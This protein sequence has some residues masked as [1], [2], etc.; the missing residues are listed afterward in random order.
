MGEVAAARV[1]GILSLE[2]AAKVICRRSRLLR[3][4]AGKGAMGLVELGMAE[5]QRALAGYEDR[6]SVAVSNGPQSTVISGDPAALEEVLAALEARSVFCRRVKVDVASH[7]PQMDPLRDDLFSTLRNVRPR[8]GQLAMRST[9][10][11]EAL[12]GPEC[13]ASY[14]VK[15]L[16]EPV[17]FSNAVQRLIETQ[18][19]LF[20]EMSP[21]PILLPAIEEN[22][23]DKKQVGT[24]VGS[25]RRNAD[26]RRTMLQGLGA[27]YA[28]GYPVDW[29]SLAP[30]DGRCVPLPAYPWQRKRYWIQASAATARTGEGTGHPLLG[31]CVPVAGMSAVYE[32]M[33]GL[34]THPWL[35]D[36]RV[37]G[38]ALVPGA[39]V[40]EL[41]RAAGAD[42]ATS[43]SG[44]TGLVLQA[45]L[46]LPETGARRVQVVLTD[47]ASA[48]VYSQSAESTARAAW[49]LHATASVTPEIAAPPVPVDLSALKA[50]CAE[51]L[52]V[53][54]IHAT[55]AEAGIAYGPA[56]RG[57]RSLWR[58]QG[59]SL[60]EVALPADVGAKG[61]GVHPALLDAAFHAVAAALPASSSAKGEMLLPFEIGSLAVHVAGAKVAWVHARARQGAG[62]G[63]V[64][65]DVTLADA[66]GTVLVEVTDLRLRPADREALRRVNGEP[67][68][69]AF[70]Q[71][72]WREAPLPAAARTQGDGIWVVVA[73]PASAA[74][75]ALEARLASC[76]VTEP[77]GL[78]AT[79]AGA[80][81]VAGV[82]CL[83]EASAGEAPP[84]TALRVA[85]LGLAVVRA[86][87][88]RA[89]VRLWWVTPG[90]VAVHGG[91]EVRA[92]TSPIWG[93]GRTVMQEHE[94][95]GC[96]LIDL[97][98]GEEGIDALVRELSASGGETQVAWRDGRRFVARLARA[99]RGDAEPPAPMRTDGT[100]LVTGGLGALGLHVARWLAG[101]G[102]A[103]LLLT[104]RRGRD[105]PGAADAVSALEALGARVTVAAVDV[106]DREALRAV[107]D[108]IP[109][110]WPLRAVVHTAGV[111]D[112]G[113][114]AE[115]SADRFA[116]VLSPKVD[117]AWN[118]HEL[119]AGHPLDRFVLFSS[120]SGLLGAAG[121]GNYAAANTFLDAL[122]AHRR[123]RGLPGQSLAWG[124]WSEAGLAAALD[125]AKRARLT[126]Q[127]FRWMSPAEGIALFERALSRPEA[128]LG[129]TPLDLAALS[130]SFGASVPPVWQALVRAPAASPAAA[131][132][133][134][135]AAQLAALPE[136][137]RAE[138]VRAAV[139]ADAGR[140]LG[141]GGASAAPLDRPFS[142]LG[143][144]SLTAVE[145]RN[146]LGK[147]LG[148]KLSTTLAFDHPTINALTR[149]LLA[150]V[151]LV[152]EPGAV[153][154]PS[155]GVP[156]AVADAT[157]DVD[158]HS[159]LRA[160]E[161]TRTLAGGR[162]ARFYRR[163][164]AGPTLLFLHGFGANHHYWATLAASLEQ[165]DLLIPSLPGRCGTDG[166]AL[167]TVSEAA[168]W[169]ASIS[170]PSWGSG[171]WWPSAT[172]M[173][174]PSPWSSPSSR[175]RFRPR[176]AT[177]SARW[178]SR[179]RACPWTRSSRRSCSPVRTSPSRPSARSP[180]SSAPAPG[181]PPRRASATWPEP[182]R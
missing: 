17:R 9:V 42:G 21:H 28:A 37:A 30:P 147:R 180:F 110:E 90:A 73:A 144:D 29:R 170:S 50:R 52:D 101:E 22:L 46:V 164:G 81:S 62:A 132:E 118:L 38:H 88:D 112:D 98:P 177:S 79:L 82:V 89:P 141:F 136:A 131:P 107:L 135:W 126:R 155:P 53:T 143:L 12:K 125:S 179:R 172:R 10:T 154:P 24:A 1:A 18:H 55:L 161:E 91:E 26:E 14:W 153:P 142:E 39:A 80:T 54:A 168:R 11:G 85:T 43:G 139:Q 71:L 178:R 78:A 137:R 120:V 61:Y 157:S 165:R 7:S 123:A 70:Y 56:F 65:A 49:T 169:I 3:R 25:L 4:V 74:A 159:S 145:L 108:A 59:E 47:V 34:A 146:A 182:W 87:L 66:S 140:V 111:L 86:L 104:G 84:A 148:K 57:L 151:L 76:V 166:P 134:A 103:H 27:V 105:T 19:T 171:R 174:A 58:G 127:G 35:G 48:S 114:L 15:N 45:P 92:A 117:G 69:E 83:W 167:G 109:A 41:V 44:V 40:A 5:A 32:G 63:G 95:L 8:A 51:V 176:S 129:V 160:W 115:Q 162:R 67:P 152:T 102:V 158:W 6:L 113:M 122:A 149:W 97:G 77:A 99:E 138:E 13:D 121:Q 124:A 94:D 119:T 20:I 96:T 133:G 173:A 23:V 60:A 116:R 181:R 156:S 175:P 31:V 68:I 128:H 150:E 75:A 100:V 16:R 2:D 33:L 93:L 64:V 106:A 130:R 163:T 72:S 36:H